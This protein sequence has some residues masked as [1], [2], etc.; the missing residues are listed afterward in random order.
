MTFD[1]NI[2][3]GTLLTVAFTQAISTVTTFYIIKLL[4]GVHGSPKIK[5]V[6]KKVSK[7]VKKIDK[8]LGLNGQGK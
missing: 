7:K 4:N 6:T 3:M 1:F 5:S 2:S 8:D